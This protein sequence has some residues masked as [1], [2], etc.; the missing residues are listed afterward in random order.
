MDGHS[1]KKREAQAEPTFFDRSGGSRPQGRELRRALTRQR[2]FDGTRIGSPAKS[3][4]FGGNPV[5]EPSK[6]PGSA[7][8]PRNRPGPKGSGRNLPR[9]ALAPS[10]VR[11]AAWESGG[12]WKHQPPFPYPGVA[13]DLEPQR[14]KT[15]RRP[16]SGRQRPAR[17]LDQSHLRRH[18]FRRR[19]DKRAGRSH[20]QSAEP[21]CARDRLGAASSRTSARLRRAGRGAR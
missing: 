8:N 7:W 2:C 16:H 5:R 12:W 4:G 19:D 21:R 20:P 11:V 9:R 6:P 15:A 3:Q 13:S 18:P 14:P 10:P 1:R 17:S